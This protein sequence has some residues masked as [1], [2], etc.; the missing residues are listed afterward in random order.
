MEAYEIA[1]LRYLY[2]CAKQQ[3]RYLNK[4]NLIHAQ[5]QRAIEKL[6]KK[7]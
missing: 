3:H 7:L 4:V 5:Y 6:L 1:E 2:A